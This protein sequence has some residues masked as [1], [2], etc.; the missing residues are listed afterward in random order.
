MTNSSQEKLDAA[1]AAAKEKVGE[2]KTATPDT[3]NFKKGSDSKIVYAVLEKAKKAL[4][5]KEIEERAVA[6]SIKNPGRAKTVAN[7]FVTNGIANK[8]D[9]GAIA[10]KP[11]TPVV[12][13]EAA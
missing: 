4:T 3:I 2:K 13:E 6:K 8:D 11:K 12:L 9:K 7:W 1:K 10:L 5:I